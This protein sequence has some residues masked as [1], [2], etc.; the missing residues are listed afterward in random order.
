MN[1]K[2]IRSIVPNVGKILA[3]A[4]ATKSQVN[5][6]QR[7]GPRRAAQRRRGQPT[8]ALPAA[9]TTHVQPRFSIESRTA[10]SCIVSGT[11]LVYSIP[12]SILDDDN[13]LFSLFPANPAYWTGTKVSQIAPAY[14]TYRPLEFRVS[15]IPQVAVTQQGTVFMGTLWNGAA[16]ADN[17]QQSLFTS[18]GGL[19]T[20]CY[21]PA[22]RKV[23]L[24][25]NLQQNLFTMND[26]LNPDTCPFLYMAG[27]RGAE[28][29]PGYF[30]VSYRYEFRNPLGSAW[31]YATTPGLTVAD[32]P[33]VPRY[34]NMS[35]VLME[36]AAGFGPGTIMDYERDGTITYHGTR[37]ALA[38]TVSVMLFANQQSSLTSQSVDD[39]TVGAITVAGVSYNMSEA[40]LE[41]AGTPITTTGANY[42]IPYIGTSG[43]SE[44]GLASLSLVYSKDGVAS[45]T[46]T[47]PFYRLPE[48]LVSLPAGS[49]R[50][51]MVSRTGRTLF[52]ATN[53]GSIQIPW[54]S[55]PL[56]AP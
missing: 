49:P 20:Q 24:G 11:D 30:Y 40:I 2:N 9:Y 26:S 32:L 3:D 54:A 27:V 28:V 25:R 56:I 47:T 35:I 52:T 13:T 50:I 16:P 23:S 39:R 21:V 18:N 15:Y 12:A 34:A 42:M 38:T 36:S 51:I 17:I 43:D 4:L 55:L 53:A 48:R 1:N 31:L 33:G 6:K 46:P 10:D 7:R 41:P 22:D 8:A 14:M 29:V 5:M 44:S 19:L 37:I 45:A